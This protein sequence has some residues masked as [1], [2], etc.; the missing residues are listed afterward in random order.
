[1]QH[2]EQLIT[3]D[4]AGRIVIPKEVRDDLHLTE[5][6]TLK[7]RTSGDDLILAPQLSSPELKRKQGLLICS[8]ELLATDDRVKRSR[9]DRTHDLITRVGL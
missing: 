7:L 9:D 8:G 1:M 6:T 2:I 5:G 3:M 4:R